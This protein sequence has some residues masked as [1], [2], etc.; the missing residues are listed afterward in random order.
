MSPSQSAAIA[1][2]LS[3]ALAAGALAD[4]HT[5]MPLESGRDLIECVLPIPDLRATGKW[6]ATARVIP[7]FEPEWSVSLTRGAKGEVH[8]EVTVPDGFRISDQYARLSDQYPHLSCEKAQQELKM[9]RCDFDD[10]RYPALRAFAGRLEGQRWPAVPEQGRLYDATLY[11][12]R[13]QAFWDE[14]RILIQGP[15]DRRAAT[16]AWRGHPIVS[17]T[18]DLYRLLGSCEAKR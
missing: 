18:E 12:V 4:D 10:R 2:I 6:A 16:R 5:L 17:W 8:A 15:V 13:V 11:E 3:G 7:A 9:R 14:T 1:W